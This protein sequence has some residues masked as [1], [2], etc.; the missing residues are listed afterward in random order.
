[1]MS[2]IREG[3]C[4][5]NGVGSSGPLELPQSELRTHYR[6]VISPDASALLHQVFRKG[7]GRSRDLSLGVLVTVSEPRQTAN[8]HNNHRVA[9]SERH[10]RRCLGNRDLNR[11][12]RLHRAD[13]LL[14]TRV[15]A[16]ENSL[17][18]LC[19]GFLDGEIAASD[20]AIAGEHGVRQRESEVCF[21]G[22][23]G[24]LPPNTSGAKRHEHRF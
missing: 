13:G 6:S 4:L 23:H 3:S 14:V 5:P 20:G 22:I 15:A 16:R 8:S 9:G 12:P 10:A 18:D 7:E 11:E 17:R 24:V 2:P 21:S 19:L 1:M